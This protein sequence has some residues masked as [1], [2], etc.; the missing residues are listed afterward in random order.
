MA[1]DAMIIGTEKAIDNIK[2]F[3]MGEKVNGLIH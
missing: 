1:E 3:I 2:L